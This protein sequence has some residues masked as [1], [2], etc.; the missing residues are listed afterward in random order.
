MLG[1]LSVVGYGWLWAVI[2]SL[3]LELGPAALS[4]LGIVWPMLSMVVFVGTG[5]L[6]K[7]RKTLA[8]W[9]VMPLVAAGLIVGGFVVYGAFRGMFC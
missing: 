1:S 8:R 9:I 7:K 6:L 2:A 3:R 5:W 4:A